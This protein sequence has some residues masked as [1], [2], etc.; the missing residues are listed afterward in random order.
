MTNNSNISFKV[1][2]SKLVLSLFLCML[3]V[4]TGIF[5][6]IKS[7]EGDGTSFF[8]TPILMFIAGL[9]CVVFFSIVFVVGLRRLMSSKP[10]LEITEE[11][12]IDNSSG[13]AAGLILW[14]D[15]Q[16]IQ[17][18]QVMFQK[19]LMIIVAN[20]HDYI[21]RQ[22]NALKKRTMKMNFSSYGSPISISS[23][24]LNTNFQELQQLLL[25]KL[26]E[27]RQKNGMHN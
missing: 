19:F 25:Q 10:G 7:P 9:I 2:K 4:V 17:T 16:Q 6:V 22:Q 27:Y 15:I 3:F 18:S 20:P 26:F 8:K 14:K 23:N 5:M 11:G 12:I 1:N 24:I 21:N 13:V